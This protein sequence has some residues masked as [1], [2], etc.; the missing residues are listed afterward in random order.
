MAKDIDDIIN[1]INYGSTDLNMKFRLDDK[2]TDFEI[3]FGHG[4]PQKGFY[5][6]YPNEYFNASFLILMLSQ[7]R[8]ILY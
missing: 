1:Y 4:H 3:L 2:I 5:A 7:N 6:E 8:Q